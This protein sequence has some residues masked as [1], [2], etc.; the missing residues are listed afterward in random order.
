MREYIE[1]YLPYCKL[2]RKN[3]ERRFICG[4]PNGNNGKFGMCCLECYFPPEFD[5]KSHPGVK[6]C[7]YKGR[8]N[9]LARHI[10]LLKAHPI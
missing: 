3:R 6:P 9:I 10:K 1:Q 2:R 4:E 5:P 7:T 8:L